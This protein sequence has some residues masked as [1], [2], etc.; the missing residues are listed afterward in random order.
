MRKFIKVLSLAVS[1]FM[2]F[3]SLGAISVIA[4]E[5]ET[6][7]FVVN[8]NYEDGFN[9]WSA[10][11]DASKEFMSV[12][13]EAKMEGNSGL[14]LKAKGVGGYAAAYQIL[15]GIV[16]NTTYT[17]SFYAKNV[18]NCV[19]VAP[20]IVGTNAGL[21]MTFRANGIE[22]SPAIAFKYYADNQGWVKY[23][24]TFTTPSDTTS[25][26]TPFY[27]A[28]YIHM[29]TAGEWNIDNVRIYKDTN[30]ISNGDL[31]SY[32]QN[33]ITGW[34]KSDNRGEFNTNYFSDTTVKYE[35][36]ASLKVMS[37]DGTDINYAATTTDLRYGFKVTSMTVGR[38]Y[39]LSF[40]TRASNTSVKWWVRNYI[41]SD[42][43]A[44]GTLPTANEWY[45]KA[46]YFTAGTPTSGYWSF[47][48]GV[49]GTTH[50]TVWYDDF[51][52]TE[53]TE[54]DV[55][56]GYSISNEAVAG[57]PVMTTR[58]SDLGKVVNNSTVYAL[59]GLSNTVTD[60]VL[61]L[62]VYSEVNGTK[63][64]QSVSATNTIGTAVRKLQTKL[65]IPASGSYEVQS[66]IWD[67]L[68]GLQNLSK[69]AVLQ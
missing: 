1:V 25:V 34:N 60:A 11:S 29:C 56:L 7:E 16:P 17:L 9:G 43:E 62:G 37:H 36:A 22:G 31:E 19:P 15:S 8:G 3:A 14:N 44:N 12:T 48:V 68:T 2:L 58:A 4:G 18:V 45:E 46:Y 69:K 26:E 65:T 35:G 32:T 5:N 52:L 24:T 63:T 23:S 33:E 47:Y 28:F 21:R 20:N 30:L 57:K 49:S 53:V 61:I 27:L 13:E 40:K 39:K 59:G 55:T 42:Y 66:F 64:L 10:N 38:T 41:P 67:S 50:G 54:G 51:R 6:S